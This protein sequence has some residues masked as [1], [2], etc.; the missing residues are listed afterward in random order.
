MVKAAAPRRKPAARIE[1]RVAPAGVRY[2]VKRGRESA[3]GK[4]GKRRT[5]R[6]RDAAAR[7]A[8]Q[9]NAR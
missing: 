2:T 5:F 3:L 4:D 6:T 9:L 8:R 7:V 1:W